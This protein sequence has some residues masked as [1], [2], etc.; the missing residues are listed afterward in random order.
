MSDNN[1][2]QAIYVTLDALLDTRLGT[3]ARISED[4][5]LEVLKSGYHEREIDDFPQV[6][7]AVYKDLYAKRDTLTLAHSRPTGMLASLSN[8]TSMLAEQAI[9]RPYH[10]GAKVVVNTYPY[11]LTDEETDNIGRAVA[12]WMQGW[13]PVELTHISPE[14]LT[15]LHCKQHYAMM[16]VYDYEHWMNIHAEAFKTTIL[17]Q[18]LMLAPAIYFGRKPTDA[19]LAREIKESTH[20]MIAIEM[21][22]SP[23]I[24]LR[25]FDVGFFSMISNK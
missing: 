18:V 25:L 11:Q 17:P 12:A 13:A 4:A 7:M 2:V 1:N 14:S 9:V 16:I 10:D 23:L 6:D 21:L 20:P 8:L 5:A 19:E 3:I 22:A 15:P 24:Q